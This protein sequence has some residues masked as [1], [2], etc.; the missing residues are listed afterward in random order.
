MLASSAKRTRSSK[1]EAILTALRRLAR[2]E[3]SIWL[4]KTIL[5]DTF[6]TPPLSKSKTIDG[7]Q[8]DIGIN[9]RFFK[10]SA[11]G[12]GFIHEVIDES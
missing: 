11:E 6:K 12:K 1:L 4:I 10:L 9:R 2:E 3:R 8:N 5:L 7:G